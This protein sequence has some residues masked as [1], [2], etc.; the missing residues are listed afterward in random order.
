M[1]DSDTTA[2]ADKSVS[3][4]ALETLEDETSDSSKETEAQDTGTDDSEA[5][6]ETETDESNDTE[7]D[8]SDDSDESKAENGSTAKQ[9]QNRLGYQLRQI[10]VNDPF[11]AQARRTLTADYVNEEG[12]TDD[13][14]EIRQMKADSYIEKLETSRA[15]LVSDNQTVAEEIPIFN[16]ASPEFKK[17]LYDRALLRFGR[18]SLE[19][20]E[21]DAQGKQEIV[22]FKVRLLDYMREEA[23]LYHAGS[24]GSKET[25]PKSDAKKEDKSEDK[26]KKDA[27]MDA[28]SEDPGGVSDTK[29]QDTKDNDP[30]VN[31]FLDGFDSV[32]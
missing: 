20:S 9:E 8:D 15:T 31:A 28:A 23:D 22:G 18:D 5:S 24:N 7:T 13:Q 21:P 14:R 29:A 10:R 2:T 4:D 26:S 25:K 27:K 32:K 6:E 19:M 16:P 12:I 3:T 17:D 1:A 30:I 11:V